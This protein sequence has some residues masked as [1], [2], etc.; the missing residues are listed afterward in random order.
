MDPEVLDL[1]FERVQPSEIEELSEILIEA[2]DW[3]ASR[4]IALWA[5]EKLQPEVLRPAVQDG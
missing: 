2:A 3:L 1:K 4:D 5:L